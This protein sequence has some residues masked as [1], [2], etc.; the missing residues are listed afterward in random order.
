MNPHKIAIIQPAIPE[1]RSQL[2]KLLS[3]KYRIKFYSCQKDFFNIKTVYKEK[4]VYLS[5]G[6]INFKYFY[7]HKKLPIIKILKNNTLIVVNGNIRVLNYLLLIVIGRVLNKNVIVWTHGM[8]AGSHG[9]SFK[10][11]RLIMNLPKSL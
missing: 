8:S 6:F 4:N 9:L 3:A 11:R 10:I 2:F 1:Y 7:W 5:D